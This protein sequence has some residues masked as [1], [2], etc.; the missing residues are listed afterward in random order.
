MECVADAPTDSG[1]S[2][3]V[4]LRRTKTVFY[5]AFYLRLHLVLL[6]LL[7]LRDQTTSDWWPRWGKRRTI[8]SRLSATVVLSV[9]GG[10]GG[11]SEAPEDH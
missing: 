1:K 2:G 4:G 7:R 10:G 6:L 5:S 11:L 9:L 3:A 8:T